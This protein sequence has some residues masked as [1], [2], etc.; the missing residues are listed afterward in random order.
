MLPSAGAVGSTEFAG[1]L[2]EYEF[3][4]MRR[5]SALA[6]GPFLGQTET[7]IRVYIGIGDLLKLKELELSA[8]AKTGGFR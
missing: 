6:G 1:V 2:C 5:L 7:V 4:K 3:A 8:S